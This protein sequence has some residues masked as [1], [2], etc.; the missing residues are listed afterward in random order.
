[1]IEI[2]FT[3]F[4]LTWI[5]AVLIGSEYSFYYKFKYGKKYTDWYNSREI[6]Q[7]YLKIKQNKD[8]L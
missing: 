6:F 1:M 3:I 4:C 5:K 8:I 7:D 2:I